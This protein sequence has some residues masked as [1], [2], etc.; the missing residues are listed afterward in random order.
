[1]RDQSSSTPAATGM[2]TFVWL[3]LLLLGAIW[4]ASFFFA[5]IALQTL[6]PLTLVF[7][8]VLIAALALLLYLAIRGPSVRALL[9]FAGQFA[10]L[11]ILNNIIPFSLIFL[12]QTRIGAGLASIIN[13]TTPFWTLVLAQAL[14]SDEKLTLNKLAGIVL[15]II[16]TAVMIGPGAIDKAGAPLWAKLSVLGASLSYAFSVIYAKRFRDLP[17]AATATG[18]LT[19]ASV[20]V[21]P[22]AL[23]ADGTTGIA[24]TGAAAWSAV[25]G[26]ALLSTAFAYI[27]YFAIIRAAGATNAS[28]VTLV[29]PASAILLG[30]LFLGEQLSV[31]G[32]AGLALIAV[33]LLTIDG[34]ILRFRPFATG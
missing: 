17:P 26:I 15:G 5:H 22:I 11:A 7:F 12:G 3:Q 9:P 23:L 21:L 20:I 33:G 10:I 2:A 18:Q 8:R 13:A 25:L 6:P 4:G 27:L 14:T 31:A 19:A 28:L 1:M 32:Y 16:G 29:V 30:G 34:R 24:S